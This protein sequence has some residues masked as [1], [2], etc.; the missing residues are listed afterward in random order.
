MARRGVLLP[1]SRGLPAALLCLLTVWLLPAPSVQADPAPR[2]VIVIDDLGN[3]R[4][5]GEAAI[6]LPGNLT[7]SVLPGLTWSTHLAELAH[8]NGREVML[9]MPMDN[10]G[11]LPLGPMGLKVDMADSE[12][13]A[14]LEKALDDVPHAAG[15]N[16]HM[17]SLLTE[18]GEPMTVVMEA[19][20]ERDLYFMD[21]L[22]S[23]RSVA[24]DTARAQGV[25]ALRRQVF[26]DHEPT[27]AFISGQFSQA[28][29]IMERHGWVIMIGHP[30]PET[31]EF[32]E[33]LLPLLDETGVEVVTPTELIRSQS[34]LS[35]AD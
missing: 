22:T 28:L 16:N 1:V 27:D 8:A 32:L 15:L 9:H 26:L 18:R 12:W 31:I 19:L 4:R 6:N 34:R 14:T 30:Y 11:R 20:A 17:G 13:R 35:Q 5:L 23:P 2:M 29:A 33:W 24:Y 21:S 7:F 3:N 10:H 25:P